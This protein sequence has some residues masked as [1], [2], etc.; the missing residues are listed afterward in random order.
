M[1]KAIRTTK[2]RRAVLQLFASQSLPLSAYDIVQN[3]SKNAI[4]TN[5]ATIYRELKRLM[6]LGLLREVI[7]KDGKKRYELVSHDSH[8]HHVVC[9]NCGRVSDI[10]F[11]EIEL[12]ETI[13]EKS[14]FKIVEHTLEFFGYCKNCKIVLGL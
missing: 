2:A 12:L 11:S 7:F 8:H 6:D 4:L 9:K 13:Q 5:R 14:G 10:N 3:F 1:M